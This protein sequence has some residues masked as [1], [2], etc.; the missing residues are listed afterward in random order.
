MHVVCRS[1]MHAS[2][3]SLPLFQSWLQ[4]N[5]PRIRFVQS[6]TMRFSDSTYVFLESLLLDIDFWKLF[7]QAQ[8]CSI[9]FPVFWVS[10]DRIVFVDRIV[11]EFNIFGLRE[12]FFFIDY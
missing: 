4:S 6:A 7:F 8:T 2:D 12:K 5:L 1:T 3:A 10:F 11:T 9:K